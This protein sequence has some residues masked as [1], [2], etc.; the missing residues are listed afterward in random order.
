[1]KKTQMKVMETLPLALNSWVEEAVAG[2][3]PLKTEDDCRMELQKKVRLIYETYQMETG[4][5]VLAEQW[6][7]RDMGA[8][9]NMRQELLKEIAEAKKKSD[10]N[11]WRLPFKAGVVFLIISVLC[12]MCIIAIQVTNPSLLWESYSLAAPKTILVSACLTMAG[13]C[14][15]FYFA[16]RLK[17]S[18]D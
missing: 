2:I 4:N 9:E 8:A 13:A 1:M 10:R 12:W 18:E 17:S 11:L 7:I 3:K 14:C 6:T 15:C 16:R 5:T